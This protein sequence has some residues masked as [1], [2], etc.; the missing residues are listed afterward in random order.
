MPNLILEYLP[1]YSP[2][3]NLIELVWHSAKEFIAHRLF[4]SVDLL[5]NKKKPNELFCEKF[6]LLLLLINAYAASK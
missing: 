2:G 4:K 3:L 6:S 5:Q 1:E